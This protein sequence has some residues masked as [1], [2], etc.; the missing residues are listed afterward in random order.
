MGY[1]IREGYFVLPTPAGAYYAV[2]GREENG[3]RRLLRRL[4]GQDSSPRLDIE[5]LQS[6]TRA[7][8]PD[9]A[10][11]V[12]FH[13]QSLG[14]VEGFREQQH[15]PSGALESML[16][17]RLDAL[18]STGK[19]ML[20]DEHGFYIASRGFAHETAEELSAVSA[21]LGSLYERHRGLLASNL[22]LETSAWAL[23]DAAGNSRVGFW[24]LFIGSQRFV[25]VLGGVPRLNQPALTELIWSLSK[26][27][28][29][30]ED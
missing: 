9:E 4:V 17:E 15:A 20:A 27:Y 18:S 3:T 11:D 12:L 26:R 10:L 22:G 23:V 2:S 28:A 21:D 7:G 30:Q 13:I 16:P 1:S 14:W 25:L 29:L 6:W 8:S 24:P 5:S 19:A